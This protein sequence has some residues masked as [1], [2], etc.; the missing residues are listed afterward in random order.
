MGP[1]GLNFKRGT[2]FCSD[3]F[4]ALLKTIMLRINVLK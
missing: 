1:K 3:V 2:I 4:W